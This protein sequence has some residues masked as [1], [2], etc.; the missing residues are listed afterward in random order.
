[1]SL[2]SLPVRRNLRVGDHPHAERQE[3][4]EAGERKRPTTAWSRRSRV[5][6]DSRLLP[7]RGWERRM[8]QHTGSMIS[9]TPVAV[10]HP[11]PSYA[12]SAVQRSTFVS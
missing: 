4:R 12:A 7:A 8:L 1:M 3:A 6:R 11:T 5:R 9:A 2:G 10:F